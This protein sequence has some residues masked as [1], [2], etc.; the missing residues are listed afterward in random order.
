MHRTLTALVVWLLCLPGFCTAQQGPNLLNYSGFEG[1]QSAIAA[2]WHPWYDGYAL[3]TSQPHSGSQCIRMSNQA[4]NQISSAYQTFHLNQNIARPILLSGWSRTSSVS[5]LADGNFAVYADLTYTDGTRLNGKNAPFAV[6]THGWQQSSIQVTPAKPVAYITLHALFRYHTG[7][8]WFDDMAAAEITTG[9]LFDGQPLVPPSLPAGVTSGWYARDVAANSAVLPLLTS[10]GADSPQAGQLHLRLTNLATTLNGQVT[11]GTLV[12]TSGSARAITVYYVESLAGSGLTWWHDIRRS[13][14][15]GASGEYKNVFTVN[16]GATGTMSFYPFGCVTG[17][18]SGRAL[19]VPPLLGPRITRIGYNAD[20]DLIYVAFDVALTGQ[21]LAN[22]DGLGHGQADVAA[23][24]YNVNPAWAFRDAAAQYYTLFPEAFTRRATNDGI[25]L[26]F[27]D[28]TSIQ[29]VTDFGFAY[30]EGDNSLANDNTLGI[31]SFRYSIPMTYAMP[32]PATT[33]RTYDAALAQVV[34]ASKGTDLQDK[35]WAQAVLNSGTMSDPNQF[36]VLFQ[37]TPW[38]NG[39]VWIMNPSPHIPASPTSCTMGSLLYTK[40]LAD[41]EYAARPALD[42]EFLDAVE[43]YRDSL[44][45]S[46]ATLRY[47]DTPPTFTTDTHEPVLPEWFNVYEMVAFM[48]QDLRSRNRL[49]MANGT[50]WRLYHFVPLIDVPGAEVEWMNN[51]VWLP[52]GDPQ[53]NLRRTMA[54]HKPFLL[55]QNTDFTLFGTAQV[56][57]YFERCLFYGCFPSMFHQTG[58]TGYYW[59]TPTLYNRD[60]ALFKQ[61]L[62]LLRTLSQAGWEPVTYAVS[63]N[64]S[65]YVERYG[66]RYLTLYSGAASTAS[67]QVSI[68][69]AHLGLTSGHVQVKDDIAGTILATLPAGGTQTLSTSLDPERTRMLELIPV[70]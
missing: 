2:Y 35:Q 53:F 22:S 45:C 25:W 61:Y 11:E 65:I 5:G 39:A 26:P 69:M 7:T 13:A 30:H 60:R 29:S 41:Q 59:Q 44:D 28:P 6:G 56:K 27:V 66:T 42:G 9:S 3:D 36:N 37:N 18:T 23:V 55:L 50:G 16:E 8:V 70:P 24:R 68:D 38:N 1:T 15:I 67:A 32:M 51:G 49:L 34:Q 47:A 46:P 14:A 57:K 63:S 43:L 31:L 33:P 19:G 64:P 48:S 12:D 40:A 20:A 21:N 52:D 4:L 10:T 17:P 58:Y 54:Y 62:P